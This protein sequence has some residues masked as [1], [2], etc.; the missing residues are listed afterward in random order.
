MCAGQPPLSIGGVL[1][2]VPRVNVCG[3]RHPA[4]KVRR[5]SPRPTRTAARSL[6]RSTVHAW[7]WFFG[8]AL[9]QIASISSSRPTAPG[10]LEHEMLD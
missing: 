1:S 2:H 3:R 7:A 4:G 10:P 5:T 8:A 6:K 9:A